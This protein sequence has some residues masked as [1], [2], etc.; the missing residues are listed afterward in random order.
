MPSKIDVGE[1][2]PARLRGAG[3]AIQAETG[4]P[5]CV[6]TH[7][8][9]RRFRRVLLALYVAGSLVLGSALFSP[10]SADQP[11]SWEAAP[12]VSAFDFVML[13]LIL[14]LCAAALITLLTLVPLLISDRGYQP[15][16]SWRSQVEWFGGPTKGVKAAEEITREQVEAR[17]R[18]TG[19]TSGSW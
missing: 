1:S 4:Y 9:F 17:S 2:M 14:P 10:A 19:G 7:D 18:E 8:V 12:D 5:A 11:K 6:L 13:L 16:Q 3:D 15:G